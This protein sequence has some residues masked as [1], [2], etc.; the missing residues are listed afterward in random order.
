M[1]D[2]GFEKF[3]DLH[4]LHITDGCAESCEPFLMD[5]SLKPKNKIPTVNIKS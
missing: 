2:E 5:E 3:I 1:A 4:H